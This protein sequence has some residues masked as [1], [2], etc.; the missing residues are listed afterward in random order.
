MFPYFL[1]ALK[2]EKNAKAKKFV[3]W[4]FGEKMVAIF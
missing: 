3:V 1:I 4:R 2:N